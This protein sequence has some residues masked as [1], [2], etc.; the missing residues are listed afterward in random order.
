MCHN[1]NIAIRLLVGML[2][3]ANRRYAVGIL[4]TATLFILTLRGF[5]MPGIRPPGYTE[6]QREIHMTQKE[7][8]VTLKEKVHIKNFL[9]LATESGTDK[10]NPHEFQFA[11]EKYL[12]RLRGKKKKSDFWRLA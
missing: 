12:P 8:N 6:Q 9:Q 10:V 5:C 2:D 4:V 3:A 1:S 7:S 11:Y